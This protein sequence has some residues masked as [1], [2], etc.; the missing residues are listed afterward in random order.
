MNIRKFNE[1]D[2][3]EILD[4]MHDFYNSPA[5]LHKAPDYVFENDIKDCLGN[6][7]YVEGYVFEENKNIMGYSILAI[8]YSTEFGGICVWIE[9]LYIKSEFRGKGV[10][11]SFFEFLENEYGKNSVRF[12]LEVE[13][14]NERAIA[15]YKKAGFSVAP[16]IQMSKEF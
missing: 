7:P 10:G 4:M 8:S 3:N 15:L 12:R 6:C 5:V 13:S 14:N 9:D 1:N 2:V 11:S 16:Y